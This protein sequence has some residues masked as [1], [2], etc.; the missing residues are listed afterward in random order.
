MQKEKYIRAEAEVVYFENEDI[1]TTSEDPLP[2]IEGGE[3][4]I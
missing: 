2:D 1:I 3:G 4:N